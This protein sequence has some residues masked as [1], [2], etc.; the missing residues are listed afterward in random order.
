MQIEKIKARLSNFIFIID[1]TTFIRLVN[2]DKL[3]RFIM[4]YIILFN[5]SVLL[6]LADINKLEVFFNNITN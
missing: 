3:P 5:I 1:S 2:L 6:H 4:F